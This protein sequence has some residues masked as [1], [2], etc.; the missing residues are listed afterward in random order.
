[1]NWKWL[2]DLLKKWFPK[3]P[4]PQPQP[5]P[6]QDEQFPTATMHT[7]PASVRAWPV[8]GKLT[9]RKDGSFLYFST[10]KPDLWPSHD[11]TCGHIHC[12]LK[13]DGVWHGGPCDALRP[14]GRDGG[15]PRKETKCACVPDNK[16]QLYVPQAG[17]EVRFV[18]TGFCRYGNDM[19][20]QQRT[21]EA[22]ITW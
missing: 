18:I 15:A 22:V 13:R 6:V 16:K 1:M 20:P 19:Q 5:E 4:K 7:C 8:V 3:K 10:D 21:T 9:V 11:G 17:E 14:F 12:L 2:T